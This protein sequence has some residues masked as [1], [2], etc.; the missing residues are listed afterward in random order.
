VSI[1][2]NGEREIAENGRGERER[3]VDQL[4]HPEHCGGEHDRDWRH[5]PRGTEYRHREEAFAQAHTPRQCPLEVSE[6]LLSKSH[7][8]D[9]EAGRQHLK[10]GESDHREAKYASELENAPP[11]TSLDT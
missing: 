2:A 1:T 10:H 9:D 4:V 5:E 3:Q 7:R 11:V 8:H 6:E